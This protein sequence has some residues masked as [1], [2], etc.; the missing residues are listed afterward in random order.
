MTNCN[1]VLKRMRRDNYI[2]VAVDSQPYL[3]FPADSKMRKDSMKI[4]HFLAIVDFYKQVRKIEE[5]EMFIVEPKFGGK[6]NPEC[7]CF[8]LWKGAAWMVEIQR[9]IYSNKV[10]TDKMNRYTNYYL[11]NEWQQETWQPVNN[12]VFPHVW[13]ITD[14]Q[15]T[16]EKQPFRVIQSKSVEELMTRLKPKEPPKTP[17][18]MGN[19]TTS[20]QSSN[21]GIKLNFT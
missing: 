16:I 17:P 11:S 3:Y 6:G 21:G 5:P 2:D 19:V 1:G 12:K 10:L 9:N 7:D 20:F 13:F 15:Y 4:R 8:L 18:T 14:H